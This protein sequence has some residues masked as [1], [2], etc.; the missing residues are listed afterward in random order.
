MGIVNQLYTTMMVKLG[1]PGDRALE[2]QSGAGRLQLSVNEQPVP[3]VATLQPIRGGFNTR[4][5]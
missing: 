4:T 2:L 5:I 3:C 1:A